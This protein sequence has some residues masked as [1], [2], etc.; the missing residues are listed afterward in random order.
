MAEAL[1][2]SLPAAVPSSPA[3]SGVRSAII[4]T[5]FQPV[6]VWASS[7]TFALNVGQLLNG[8]HLA[9]EVTTDLHSVL[10]R[11]PDRWSA[12]LLDG[13]ES[14]VMGAVQRVRAAPLWWSFPIILLDGLPHAEMQ[15]D[16]H[17]LQMTMPREA[18][19]LEVVLFRLTR[20][21]RS[22][23]KTVQS[24][25]RM[26]YRHICL[27][28]VTASMDLLLVDLSETGAQI[29]A[30]FYLPPGTVLHLNLS[31]LNP[32]FQRPLTFKIL[33]AQPF[34]ATQMTYR[35]RGRFEELDADLEKRLRRALMHLQTHQ[36]RKLV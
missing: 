30:P 2:T 15:E 35:M 12:L 9:W 21:D 18:T 6:L 36:A 7:Q 26:S 23:Q 20:S 14:R 10:Q 5:T 25:A 22:T 33:T 27:K 28:P 34:G 4:P 13:S 17:L 31:R 32:E 24:E 29:E 3:P 1:N 19:Q 11:S 16:R 8:S